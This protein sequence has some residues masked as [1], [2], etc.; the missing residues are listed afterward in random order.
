M[1]MSNK[2]L[3]KLC[4]EIGELQAELGQLQQVIGKKLACM[5]TDTHWD[6]AF[7][8]LSKR[9]EDEFADVQAAMHFVE[10]KL[11]LNRRS[12]SIRAVAKAAI[13]AGWDAGET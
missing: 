10:N 9:L 11:G 6:E 5:D 12:I 1:P 4:E 3:S 13:F 8:P 2:G 7:S